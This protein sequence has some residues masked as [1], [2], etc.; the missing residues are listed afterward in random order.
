MT[1]KNLYTPG[2]CDLMLDNYDGF[3]NT[4]EEY[5]GGIIDDSTKGDIQSD[6]NAA[7]LLEQRENCGS[8]FTRD[9]K[10]DLKTHSFDGFYLRKMRINDNYYVGNNNVRRDMKVPVYPNPWLL[11]LNK[12]HYKHR[13]A[14]KDKYFFYAGY[15]VAFD[16]INTLI[17]SIPW[18]PRGFPE[19]L[20]HPLVDDVIMANGAIAVA[21]ES[22]YYFLDA[23]VP[24]AYGIMDTYRGRLLLQNG[25]LESNYNIDE[26]MPDE[27]DMNTEPKFD[28]AYL[29]KHDFLVAGSNNWGARFRVFG[30]Y[31]HDRLLNGGYFNVE[32]Y[33]RRTDSNKS[34]AHRKFDDYYASVQGKKPQ[35][36]LPHFAND[37][38]FV[39]IGK[40]LED[41]IDE[42]SL[43]VEPASHHFGE[44]VI[45]QS[46]N[47]QGFTVTNTGESSLE[48]E[49]FSLSGMHQSEFGINKSYTT[50]SEKVHLSPSDNCTIS[51]VFSP[52]S[53]GEKQAAI[54]IA[55]NDSRTPK[56]EIPLAGTGTYD[57]IKLSQTGQVTQ[58]EAGDDGDIQAG[59]KW[60]TPRFT[61]N[62]D[63]TITD[64]LTGL[65]WLKQSHCLGSS[66]VWQDAFDKISNFNNK[67][68][69]YNCKEY[70]ASYQDWRLANIN[71]LE[72]LINA[73]EISQA[74]WLNKQGIAV[75][76]TRYWT[77][78]TSVWSKTLAWIINLSNSGDIGT[79][80]KETDKNYILP[81]RTAN[82][83]S[84]AAPVWKTGQVTSH[85]G[86]DDGA[87][88]KGVPWPEPRFTYNNDGTVTDNITGLIWLNDASC[89]ETHSW[90]NALDIAAKFNANPDAN[91]IDYKAS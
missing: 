91:C 12:N 53:W 9:T 83:S 38:V 14:T 41:I 25:N 87:L 16:N 29:D 7:E 56:F 43:S 13:K 26:S 4:Y 33:R 42:T 69:S 58:Y 45:S 27:L 67:S 68:A 47:V 3:I 20:D 63:G 1:D 89:L 2:A 19:P 61:D 15:V 66:V 70:K 52:L 10:Y 71:E 37:P 36:D 28:S 30:D 35:S 6:T 79:G 85:Y 84:P 51:I 82:I 46:S 86:Q 8:V 49:K 59:V 23:V 32:K 75:Q 81:V 88:Q 34:S 78:T 21:S 44:T 65:M 72:S 48:I 54:I 18:I 40:D 64:N 62:Q 77:S 39:Q 74:I 22:N 5:E 90:Q 73:N 11:N 60:P 80:L 24:L 31:N 17:G 57:N 50:C 76:P 55:S